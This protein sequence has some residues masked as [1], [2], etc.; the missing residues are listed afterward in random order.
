MELRR[1]GTTSAAVRRSGCDCAGR[2]GPPPPKRRREDER[3]GISIH[4][5]QCQVLQIEPEEVI[6]E[7]EEREELE[8]DGAICRTST[9]HV[10]VPLSV[11]KGQNS[12]AQMQM[13]YE[14]LHKKDGR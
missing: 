14:L 7:R 3:V 13:M 8:G 11:C 12:D 2:R 1:R 5:D 4:L 9:T 6:S 10:S